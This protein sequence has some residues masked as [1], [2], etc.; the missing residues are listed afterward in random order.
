MV[1]SVKWASPSDEKCHLSCP[2]CLCRDLYWYIHADLFQ[3]LCC[4]L[5]HINTY[6][7]S[8]TYADYKSHFFAVTIIKSVITHLASCSFQN[9]FCFFRIVII[10]LYIFIIV[11]ISLKRTI[12]RHS[13]SQEH[14][15]DDCLTVKSVAYSRDQ[16]TVFLP[17]FISKVKHDSTIVRSLHI[18]A[19]ICLI[20]SKSSCIL[21]C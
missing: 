16:V 10:M 4:D 17:V 14:C 12:S 20:I 8:C 19:C 2:V 9:F 1:V 18:V 5:S 15:I 11:D 13:L 21:W 3:F 7:I 6:L